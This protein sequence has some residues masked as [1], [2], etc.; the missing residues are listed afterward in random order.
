MQ[1]LHA[2][3][4]HHRVDS[5]T[6][7]VALFTIVAS[8]FL[9]SA[10]WLDPVGGLVISGMIVQAG[11][12]NTKS[13]LLELADVGMDEEAR[14]GAE[15][16]AKAAMETTDAEIRGVQGIKSGQNLMFEVE[17]A[18]PEDW[19]MAHSN[20]IEIEIRDAIIEKVKGT[21]RVNLR[22]T[23]KGASHAPFADQF[24]QK[25]EDLIEHDHEHD[26]DHTHDHDHEHDHNGHVHSNGHATTS[27]TSNGTA[28]KRK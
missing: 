6:A 23:T 11:F 12:V 25:S 5:L 9:E 28:H 14:E 10:R 1:C 13:A 18:V 20:E 2:K 3:A 24:T 15:S 26:H 27:S 7:F 17:V 16:A 21:K 8:H 22:F 4:Y 19:S